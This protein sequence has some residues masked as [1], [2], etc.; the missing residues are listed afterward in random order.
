MSKDLHQVI[1]HALAKARAMGLDDVGQLRTAVRWVLKVRP[2]LTLDEAE[3]VV[4][5]LCWPERA[6]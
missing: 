2:H 6:A 5:S 3:Q 1:H 4:A